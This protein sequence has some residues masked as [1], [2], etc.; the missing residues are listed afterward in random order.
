MT[1]STTKRM[2]D[3]CVATALLFVLLP[4]FLV[5]TMLILI[6]MGRPIFF[7]HQRS[8]FHKTAFS[9]IKFRTMREIQYGETTD[10]D[11][12][13]RL[14]FF[15]RKYSIDESPQLLNV[16][17]GDMSLVGPRPLLCEYDSLYS[18]AQNER[19]LLKPGITGLA[20]ISGRNDIT[21]DEKLNYD[22]KYVRTR[23][24]WLDCLILLKTVSVVFTAKGF[25]PSGEASKFGAKE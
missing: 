16:I 7:T 10:A 5:I 17:V 11:R 18:D 9:L 1:H 24:F 21:W 13:T 6:N 15:L 23:T 2:M 25:K 3:I 22:I 8:G 19:F 14:G 4:L 20:Q 12:I